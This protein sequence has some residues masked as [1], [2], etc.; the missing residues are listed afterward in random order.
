MRSIRKDEKSWPTDVSTGGRIPHDQQ[1]NPTELALAATRATTEAGHRLKKRK[2]FEPSTSLYGKE[3][4]KQ[5][6]SRSRR[7]A[8]WLFAAACMIPKE[9]VNTQ[10]QTIKDCLFASWTSESEELASQS[11]TSRKIK[12]AKRACAHINYNMN[13]YVHGSISLEIIIKVV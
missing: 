4:T 6:N 9:E 10:W 5:W 11:L 13:Y 1:I 12:H 8:K 7:P 2:D 3:N